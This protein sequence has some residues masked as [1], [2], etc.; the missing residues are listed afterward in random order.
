MVDSQLPKLNHTNGGQRSSMNLMY[1]WF[2]RF[3]HT[4]H[5]GS[6]IQFSPEH[7]LL[8]NLFDGRSLFIRL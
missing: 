8:V 6:S 5:H 3:V 2:E 4:N 1:F 7:S